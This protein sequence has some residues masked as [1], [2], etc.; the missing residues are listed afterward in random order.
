MADCSQLPNLPGPGSPAGNHVSKLCT[1]NEVVSRRLETC[2]IVTISGNQALCSAVQW[3]SSKK[4]VFRIFSIPTLFITFRAPISKRKAP[5]ILIQENNKIRNVSNKLH[6]G[7]TGSSTAKHFASPQLPRD[8]DHVP[9]CVIIFGRFFSA[10]GKR[11]LM[12][13]TVI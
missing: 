13:T 10:G 2:L 12:E 7:N 5:N 9:F 1:A 6:F 11:W 4:R 8:M 3:E